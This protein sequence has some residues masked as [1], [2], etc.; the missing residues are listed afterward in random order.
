MKEVDTENAEIVYLSLRKYIKKLRKKTH[1]S[2]VDEYVAVDKLVENMDYDLE[3]NL[4]AS[5][6]KRVT[7]YSQPEILDFE[8]DMYA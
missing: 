6:Y 3:R 5:D 1:S 7:K 2:P 8:G 4:S